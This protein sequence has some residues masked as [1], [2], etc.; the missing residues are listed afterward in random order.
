MVFSEGTPL[1][2]SLPCSLWPTTRPYFDVF[3]KSTP[4]GHLLPCLQMARHWAFLYR[5]DREHLT[6]PFVVILTRACHWIDRC[7]VHKGHA[8]GPFIA[9]L[10]KGPPLDWPNQFSLVLKLVGFRHDLHITSKTIWSKK[11]FTVPHGED[12]STNIYTYVVNQQMHTDKIWFII[13]WYSRTCFGR[14]CDHY[15]GALQEYW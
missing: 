6:V 4:L 5:I 9:V 7:P 10:S 11:I 2:H 14:F 12:H 8:T 15:R 1:D 13:H 3:G